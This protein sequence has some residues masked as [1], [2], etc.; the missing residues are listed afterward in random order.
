MLGISKYFFNSND[1][2]GYIRG[3]INSS[4]LTALLPAAV[5]CRKIVIN[6]FFV[7]GLLSPWQVEAQSVKFE[8]SAHEHKFSLSEPFQFR[9]KEQLNGIRDGVEFI[10]PVPGDR[11]LVSIP[12]TNSEAN[13]RPD[14]SDKRGVGVKQQNELSPDT[15]HKFWR[16]L[17]IQLIVFVAAFPAG[18]YISTR[19][20]IHRE[21]R[22]RIPKGQ[23]PKA[24]VMGMLSSWF[25]PRKIKPMRWQLWEQRSCFLHNK[26]R[27]GFEI[28]YRGT[29]YWKRII[30]EK[31]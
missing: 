7:S 2:R 27:F 6:C 19:R 22:Q 13:D 11:S 30:A 25:L 8:S 12:Q 14:E 23:L 15:S 16:L 21:W 20:N 5:N 24:P 28:A 31:W 29:W 4:C 3:Q 10:K 9:S 1:G 18:V 17:L 26:I